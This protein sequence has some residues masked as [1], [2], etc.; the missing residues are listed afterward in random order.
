M[1]QMWKTLRRVTLVSCC[2]LVVLSHPVTSSFSF[3]FCCCFLVALGLRNRPLVLTLVAIPFYRRFCVV[4]TCGT[5]ALTVHPQLFAQYVCVTTVICVFSMI[6]KQYPQKKK[7]N[8]SV[9][10]VSSSV[11]GMNWC[12]PH[13]LPALPALPA[14]PWGMAKLCK[15]KFKQKWNAEM[16]NF[17]KNSAGLRGFLSS[18]EFREEKLR[19]NFWKTRHFTGLA[20]TS[21]SSFAICSASSFLRQST[22]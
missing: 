8:P 7:T 10:S 12:Q 22:L 16:L 14:E 9:P 2:I 13:L 4:D 17:K 21:S 20:S 15:A 6:T 3:A 11:L 18:T 5:V 1:N 19:C